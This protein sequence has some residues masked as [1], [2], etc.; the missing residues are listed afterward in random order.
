MTTT[1]HTIPAEVAAHVLSHFGRGGYPASDWTEALISLID[2]ADMVHR[3]K[4]CTA[5]PAYGAAIALAKYDQ[6]GITVLR[7]LTGQKATGLL[8]T[9]CG[10]NAGPFNLT[11]GQCENCADGNQQ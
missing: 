7:Q 6:N 8:C 5:F 11:T 10:G 1:N 4:L 9:N 3:A 2:R